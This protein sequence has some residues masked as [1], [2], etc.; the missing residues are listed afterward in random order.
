MNSLPDILLQKGEERRAKGR[1]VINRGA[2]IFFSG[3]AG[4][5][6]CCVRDITNDGAGIRLSKMNIVPS[7]FGISFDNFQTTRD[8]RL[9]WRDGDFIGAAFES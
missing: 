5:R 2:L 4:V 9:I 1:T 8:C 3:L 7:R 6:T